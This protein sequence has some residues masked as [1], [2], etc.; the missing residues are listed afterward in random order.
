MSRPTLVPVL[1]AP[2]TRPAA[3]VMSGDYLVIQDSAAIG[4]AAWYAGTHSVDV[5]NNSGWIFTAPP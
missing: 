5:S 1:L 4:G 3:A 2:T